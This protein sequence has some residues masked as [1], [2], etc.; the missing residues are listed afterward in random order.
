M[1]KLLVSSIVFVSCISSFCFANQSP[2]QLFP[3]SST[4]HVSSPNSSRVLDVRWLLGNNLYLA[5]KNPDTGVVSYTHDGIF[6]KK[7]KYFYQGKD[8]LQGYPIPVGLTTNDCKLADIKTPEN[9]MPPKAT[10]IVAIENFNLNASD[11]S[12]NAPFNPNDIT[13]YNYLMNASIIDASDRDHSLHLYFAKSSAN[14]WDVHVLVDNIEIGTGK[15]T[16]YGSGELSTA[17]GL[18]GLTFNSGTNAT[19]SSQV[20]DVNLAGSTQFA[21]SYM[22]RAL[23]NDGIHRGEA[24]EEIL[25]SNG[26]LSEQYTNGQV[27][28]F[29]KIAVFLH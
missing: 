22:S 8:R 2:Y 13:S 7:G 25:D 21:G 29:D 28:V 6:I 16:F 23:I 20:F 4:T 19:T 15:M 24:I 26:Y 17:T 27:A 5:I 9:V 10:S 18:T 12:V 3:T 11:T 1:R 14:I